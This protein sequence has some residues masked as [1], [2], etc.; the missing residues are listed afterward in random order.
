MKELVKKLE[1]LLK[2]NKEVVDF[3]IFGSFAKD[4]LNPKDIDIAVLCRSKETIEITLLKKD[5]S[6]IIN[7]K[8]DLQFVDITDY[9]NFL[10]ITLIREGFSV[11]YNSYLYEIYR[12][13][14]V[15]LYNYSL[16]E[17]TVSKKVMFERAIKNFKGIKKL[18]NRV[19]I[20]PISISERFNEFLR[21]WNIDIT[22]Q[23]YGLLP[24][25]RK[26]EF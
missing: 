2:T 9:N 21:E 23:E 22:S 7:K 1:K 19:I 8:I 3:I 24:L 14:P 4:K 18:S 26:E 16:K 12:I 6:T 11:K 13:N 17:M 15:V 25:V 5:I 20:V 10:W